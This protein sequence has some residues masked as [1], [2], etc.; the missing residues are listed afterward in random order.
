[1]RNLLVYDETAREVL[2]RYAFECHKAKIRCL[3]PEKIMRLAM[4]AIFNANNFLTYDAATITAVNAFTATLNSGFLRIYT[5]AQPAVNGAITGTQLASL[6]F[7][8]TAFPTAVASSG[9]VTATANAITSGTA[10]ATGTAGYHALLQSNGT[11][12]VATG[13]VGTSSADLNMSTLTVTSGNTVACSSYL[14][15]MVE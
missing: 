1:M 10:A 7:S 9:T 8:A 5:G 12:I 13:S 15:N 14:I 11:T 6:T 3:P 4:G 2:D